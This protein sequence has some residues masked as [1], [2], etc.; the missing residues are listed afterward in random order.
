MVTPTFYDYTTPIFQPAMRIVTNIT[1]AN[2][3]VVTTN[4]PHNFLNG[5]I[6]RLYVPY[7]FGMV[8]ADY[9]FAPITVLSA[10]T[11]SIAI[12]TTLFYPYNNPGTNLSQTSMAIPIGEITSQIY[13]AET[14]TLPSGSRDVAP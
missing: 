9:L 10:T 8:Q 12:D 3:A 2:P 5:E 4:I 11:F 13:A 6:V 14:N 7:D 1:Q